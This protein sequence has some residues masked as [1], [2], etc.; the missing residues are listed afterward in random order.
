MDNVLF[1]Y[2]EGKIQ[3]RIADFLKLRESLFQIQYYPDQAIAGKAQ[4]LLTQQQFLEDQ[5][6]SALAT[7]NSAKQGAD[8][9][10]G[11]IT[12]LGLFYN[13]MDSQ[14]KN[15][16]NLMNVAAGIAPASNTPVLVG[17]GLA[18]LALLFFFRSK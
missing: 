6:T 10:T 18:G 9:S 7:I 3:S 5:L 15:A 16:K 13:D 2:V 4:E 1:S 12:R 17:L 14:I 11:D 8:L